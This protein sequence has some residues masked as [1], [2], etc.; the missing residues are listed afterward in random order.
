[1]FVRVW[2]YEVQV[3]RE[4]EF[5]RIYAGDGPWANLFTRSQ[6]FLGTEL[7]RSVAAPRTFLTVDRF[8]REE[9]FR[10]IL[11]QHGERYA[12]LDDGAAAL[13]LS[14]QEIATATQQ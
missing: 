7:F 6:G 10:W 11:E 8:A 2:Q 12:E 3:G 9:D 5:V 1:M 14:E 4:G 13:T